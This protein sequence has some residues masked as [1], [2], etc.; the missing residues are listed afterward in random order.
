MIPADA[1]V[2][3]DTNVLVHLT[4]RDAVGKRLEEDHAL[5]RRA[6]RPLISFV[7]LGEVRSLALKF[8]WGRK[9]IGRLDDL[10]DQVVVVHIHQADILD[11]YASIDH[12]SERVVKP[13]RRMSK[14]DVWIAATAC[15]L[16]AVLDTTDSDFDHLVPSRFHRVKVEEGTGA[17][18]WD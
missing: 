17:S 1:L 6:Y 10:I 3:L 14:N 18:S 2:L 16:D 13:A 12:H 7:T 4:R 5:T 11:H 8:G 9:K 15:A